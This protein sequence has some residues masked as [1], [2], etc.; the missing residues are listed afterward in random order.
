M[1][2]FNSYVRCFK[3]TPILGNLLPTM[4]F[5]LTSEIKDSSHTSLDHV[6]MEGPS[7]FKAILTTQN[8]LKKDMALALKNPPLF[9]MTC[10]LNMGS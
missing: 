2:M 9:R 8:G 10:L 4:F 1:A 7:C 5:D 6:L 3:D